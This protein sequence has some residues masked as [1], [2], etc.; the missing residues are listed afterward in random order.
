MGKSKFHLLIRTVLLAYLLTAILLL[1]LALGLYRLHLTEAQINLGVNG[2]YIAAC[3]AGGFA[4]G[5]MARV[6]RFLWG[7][8]T[9]ALYFLVLLGVSF[10]INR[11]IGTGLQELALIFAM[12]AGSGAV[13]GMIS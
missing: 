10:L 7:F 5:K 1:A 6:R 8:A 4:A 11:Q 3:L 2:I 12:C 13:G 9:G